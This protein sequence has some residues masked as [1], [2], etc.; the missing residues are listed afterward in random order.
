LANPGISFDVEG[1]HQVAFGAHARRKRVSSN[2]A[3][4]PASQ[5]VLNSGLVKPFEPL[6]FV[7]GMLFAGE[8][9]ATADRRSTVHDPAQ[10]SREPAR[11]E[12]Q[13]NKR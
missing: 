10:N 9:F 7:L 3:I 2:E 6:L 11:Q 8:T 5:N 4:V 12:T 13:E 1:T